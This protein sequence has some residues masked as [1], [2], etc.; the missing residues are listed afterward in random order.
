MKRRVQWEEEGDQADLDE[1]EMPTRLGGPPQSGPKPVRTAD[2]TDCPGSASL[3]KEPK[4]PRLSP[5][6]T[7]VPSGWALRC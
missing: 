4:G 2:A 3:G 5:P 7:E 6:K 1:F